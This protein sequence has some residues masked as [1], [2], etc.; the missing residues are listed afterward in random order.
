MAFLE[1]HAQSKVL[2]KLCCFNVL[3]PQCYEADGKTPAPR[4][5][6]KVLYLLHGLGGDYMSWMRQTSIERYAS[7]IKDLVVVMP[8]GDRSFYTDMKHGLAYWTFIAEELP[9]IVRQ[10][11]PVSSRKEDTF[12]AGFSMGGY[13]ALKLAL[14]YPECFAGCG[15]LSAAADMQGMFA[16]EKYAESRKLYDIFGSP[17][18]L[19]EDGNDLFALIPRAMSK[20]DLP[21]IIQIC[22]TEDSL[23]QANE[24]LK[25]ALEAANYPG[26]RFEGHPGNHN[27]GFC[28]TY[29]QTIL[30]HFF[31]E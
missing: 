10:F 30:D 6:Y 26:Y 19:A 25:S 2:G 20:K 24:K 16:N 21:E 31:K 1:C 12:V 15:T 9:G 18:E 28:D 17:G 22:G 7:A 14:T 11:F 3:L 8:D 29:I 27:W 4:R 5:E 13:G 23:W